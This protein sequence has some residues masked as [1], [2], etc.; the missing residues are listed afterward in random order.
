[1]ESCGNKLNFHE[2][3]IL[4]G[5]IS[6][7]F[8]V[9]RRGASSLVIPMA[10]NLAASVS[11]HHCNINLKGGGGHGNASQ[12]ACQMS[13]E[14]NLLMLWRFL[15]LRMAGDHLVV[16]DGG[17]MCG[18]KLN[19][20]ACLVASHEIWGPTLPTNKSRFTLVTPVLNNHYVQSNKQKV[21]PKMT[22]STA[23]RWTRFGQKVENLMWLHSPTDQVL[24][25]S[26]ASALP[27]GQGDVLVLGDVRLRLVKVGSS[28]SDVSW[29]RK[30]CE[31]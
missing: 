1:M 22:S 13:G 5:A 9:G 17:S 4:A 15:M 18:T 3:V 23:T 6:S 24:G 28:T 29:I 16:Y 21:T 11:R 12:S 19:G 26:L 20:K 27:V 2:P 7:E 25:N 8:S 30:C 10:G 14:H 31:L